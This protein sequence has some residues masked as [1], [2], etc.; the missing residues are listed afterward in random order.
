MTRYM[1]VAANHHVVATLQQVVV[2]DGE[3]VDV[4]AAA[5]PRARQP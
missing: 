4:D 1:G 3:A 5:E 2:G